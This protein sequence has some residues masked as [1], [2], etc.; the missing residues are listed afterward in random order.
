MLNILRTDKGLTVTQ[1]MV[2][3]SVKNF[4]KDKLKPRVIYDYK[5]EVVDRSLF[6]EFGKMGIFG[7][8]ITGYNCLGESYKT[9]GLIA[10]EIE[11]IDSGYRS[12]FSVQSSLVM[13]PIFQY[14]SDIVKDNYLNGLSSG[15]LIGCFGLTEPDY[16]SD[17]STMKTNARRSGEDY[18]LNGSKMWISNSPIADVF[19]VWGKDGNGKVR[20]FVLDRDMPGISTPTIEGKLSLRTSVTGMIN[21]DDVRIP[22]DNVLNIVGM[23]GPYSCLNNAR[24][25][26]SFGVLGSAQYCME[27]AIE[28]SQ[29]RKVFNQLL[30][31]KQL[32]QMKVADM[33]TEWN[34][35]LLSCHTVADIIEEDPK[36]HPVIISMIKRNSC[37]KSLEIARKC[38]D[39]LG[40]NGISE[41]YHIFRHLCNLETV[42]TYEGTHDIHSLIMGKYFTQHNAL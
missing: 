40:G 30:A 29:H 21:L 33:A 26:I 11:Y 42:Y 39:I 2:I 23:K 4:C 27:Q 15:D 5:N 13:N 8:T 41:D 37:Q 24:L 25:G 3:E 20:G 34:N 18:I 31:E 36:Y 12:M 32:L 28:Y 22:K 6:K 17:P 7:P 1:K 35:A 14:G 38:R 16:G 19:I 9:Y 10:K